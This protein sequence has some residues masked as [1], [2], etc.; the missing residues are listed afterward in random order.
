M[1]W[2]L[3]LFAVGGAIALGNWRHGMLF[4]LVV[5]FAQDPLRKVI[6]GLPVYMQVLVLGFTLIVIL[7][8]LVQNAR[9]RLADIYGGDQRLAQAWTLFL[10]LVLLQCVHTFALYGNPILPGLGVINYLT[11]VALMVVGVSFALDEE[12]VLKFVRVYLLLAIPIALTVYL[13]FY[14]QNDWT[15]F[16]SIGRLTGR[17]L[18]IY[19]QGTVLFSNSGVMRAGEIAAWHAGTSVMLMIVMAALDRRTGFRLAVGVVVALLLGVVLLT[20]RRKMLMAAAIFVA[21]FLAILMLYRRGPKRIEAL[22]A[23]IS[24]AAAVY[25]WLQPESG[26][27]TLYEA[28]GLSVFDDAIARLTEAWG[29]AEAGFQRGGLLGLG[30]GVSA[31]GSQYF[32]GGTHITGGAAEAGGG[33]LIVEL[34]GIGLLISAYLIWR[35]VSYFHATFV[36]ISKRA[37]Y[38]IVLMSGIAALLVAQSVTFVVATQVFGDPFVLILMGLFL[39][40]LFALARNTREHEP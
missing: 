17:P 24:T 8:A 29:L 13:S 27:T 21:V 11:P 40:F 31:Q 36:T 32:G 38:R 39:S 6:P 37:E 19:D 9:F 3:A 12:W 7:C 15:V 28:R 5:G 4:L 33:K 23:V 10:A 2:V 25:F 1:I 34:G 30:A 14:F 26:Q 16:Q 18:V 22:L 20:G 35:I